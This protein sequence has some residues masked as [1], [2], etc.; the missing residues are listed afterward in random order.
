MITSCLWFSPKYVKDLTLFLH[1]LALFAVIRDQVLSFL[2]SHFLAS[3]E[4]ISTSGAPRQLP[5]SRPHVSGISRLEDLHSFCLHLNIDETTPGL[6]RHQLLQEFLWET[7]ST[8]WGR[9]HMWP[10]PKPIGWIGQTQSLRLIELP[11][12]IRY[13]WILR[14]PCLLCW[15]LVVPSCAALSVFYLF[16]VCMIVLLFRSEKHS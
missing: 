3:H 12:R 9:Q 5:L 8:R 13:L 15:L 14:V 6:L 1:G 2:T 16:V 10:A 7:L 4:K 11:P